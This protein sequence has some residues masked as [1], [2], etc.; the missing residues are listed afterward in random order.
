[1]WMRTTVSLFYVGYI[2]PCLVIRHTLTHLP[3]EN[4][5]GDRHTAVLCSPHGDQLRAR[6]MVVPGQRAVGVVWAECFP[7]LPPA[8][9]CRC[10]RMEVNTEGRLERNTRGKAFR[11]RMAAMSSLENGPRVAHSPVVP[12]ESN[13]NNTAA[14]LQITHPRW[15][16][17]KKISPRSY[18]TLSLSWTTCSIGSRLMYCEDPRGKAHLLRDAS[19]GWTVR[20]ELRSPSSSHVSDVGRR[21]P[22]HILRQ[23]CNPSQQPDCHLLQDL[24]PEAP[25]EAHL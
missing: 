19:S 21:C 8:L 23:D 2:L 22:S 25:S 14:G 24:D 12:R 11:R 15:S 17:K 10:N 1:M 3:Q 9:R 16:Y 18:L 5:S 20:E 6:H 13:R 4:T 7:S